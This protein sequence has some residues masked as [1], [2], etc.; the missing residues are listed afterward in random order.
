MKVVYRGTSSVRI[1]S[2]A[3]FASRGVEGQKDLTFVRNV[4]VNVSKAVA[5]V[6]YG[7]GDFEVEKEP[8]S[9]SEAD[10]IKLEK[11]QIKEAEAKIAPKK[12]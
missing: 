2:S 1:L 9:P 6:L 5:D 3:D 4:P 7:L 11:E 12:K 10:Q 8:A